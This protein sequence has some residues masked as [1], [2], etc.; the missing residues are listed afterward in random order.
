MLFTK[1]DCA[2]L[3]VPSF[4]VPKASVG[5][6]TTRFSL[7]AELDLRRSADGVRAAWSVVVGAASPSPPP[8]ID[9]VS[10]IIM[11]QALHSRSLSS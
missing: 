11:T 7:E 1:A 8:T 10:R 5:V 2:A 4:W 9:G 3:V 6:V